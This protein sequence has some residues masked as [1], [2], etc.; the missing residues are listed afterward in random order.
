M[1]TT[2]LTL[3]L[4]FVTDKTKEHT[5][6]LVGTVFKEVR[7]KGNLW[8]IIEGK[9]VIMTIGDTLYAHPDMWSKMTPSLRSRAVIQVHE[10]LHAQRQLESGID[11][12]ILDYLL[13][14]KFRWKEEQLAYAAEW[15]YMVKNGYKYVDGHYRVWA[16]ILSGKTYGNMVSFEESYEWVSTTMKDLMEKHSNV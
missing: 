12:W 11:K 9:R 6:L 15:E 3:L 4:S 14:E 13:D 8:L 2:I 1:I 5:E 7:L 10:A 16:E